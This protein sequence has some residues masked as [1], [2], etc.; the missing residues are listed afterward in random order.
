MDR[1]YSF[2]LDRLGLRTNGLDH[3]EPWRAVSVYFTAM[4]GRHEKSSGTF[5]GRWD[6]SH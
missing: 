4:V 3:W 5:E 2:I 1:V 6:Q